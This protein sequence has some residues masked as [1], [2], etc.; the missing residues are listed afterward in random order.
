M[1]VSTAEGEP[2]FRIVK[3]VSAKQKNM[4]SPEELSKLWRIGLKAARRTLKATSHKCIC[5]AGN[6]TRRFKTDK[7]HLRYKRLSTREG[8]FYVDTLFFKVKSIRS[9]TCSNLYTTPLG[10]KKFFPMEGK[11]CQ[12][13]SSSLQ[14]LI[15]LVGI[16]PSLHSDN[17]PA[18]TQGDFRKKYRKFDIQ[19]TAT[20]PHSPWQNRA[21]PGIQEVK[22]YASKVME[23]HQVPVRLWCFAYEYATEIH[24]LVVPGS[25]QLQNR[26][27]YES[28]MH[29]T[30][31]ILDYVNFHFYQWCYYWD[32]TEKE[33]KLGRWL[34]VAHQVGQRMCYWVLVESG[35]KIVE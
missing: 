19:Q 35:V 23:R 22:S 13:C 28:V 7:A 31:D 12:E 27:P 2:D 4:L 34:G 20:E 1:E 21:E 33:K 17:A 24:S 8:S 25:F 10:F 3:A 16:P 18:F 15:H 26:T 11:I 6:L 29:Y 32:E 5:T 14:A 9:Y 30:P